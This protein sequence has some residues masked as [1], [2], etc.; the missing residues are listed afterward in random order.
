MRAVR[1]R[2]DI[3]AT[4]A[5]EDLDV[6]VQR[7]ERE[8]GFDLILAT[9]VLVYYDRFEQALALANIAAMLRPGGV[10]VTNYL[11]HPIPPLEPAAELVTPVYRDRQPPG[12]PSSSSGAVRAP[13]P[14]SPARQRQNENRICACSVRG[15]W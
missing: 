11:V 13:R 8:E 14:F 6:V 4:L 2:P 3:A 12:T 15:A 7:R 5:A 10:F 1:V 9:N